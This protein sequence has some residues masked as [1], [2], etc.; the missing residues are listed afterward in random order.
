MSLWLYYYFLFL[1]ISFYECPES[2][3]ATMAKYGEVMADP[4][5][6]PKSEPHNTKKSMDTFFGDKF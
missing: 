6:W 2:L 5:N 1:V 4:A 3:D